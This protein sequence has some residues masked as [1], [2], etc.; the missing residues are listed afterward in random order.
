ML[1][2]VVSRLCS[3]VLLMLALTLVTFV[4]FLRIPIDPAPWIAG[5]QVTPEERAQIHH[6]LGLDRPALVQW[7]KFVERIV[8][9]GSLGESLM[10]QEGI[11]VNDIV[12]TALGRTASLVAGGFALVLL[13]SIP[14]GVLSALRPHTL[15]D[16]SVV[17]VAILGIV[18]HPFVVGLALR[19]LL[20]RRWH[21]APDGGYCP[22]HAPA[23]PPD[24][25]ATAG[26]GGLADWAGHLWLPWI[27]FAFFFLPLYTRMIRA[28]VLEN[29]GARYV[30]TARAKG[31]SEWR[32]VSRHVSRNVAGPVL[33]MLAV[34]V[35]T[36][37]TAAIYIETIFGLHGIGQLV[38][39]NLDGGHGYDLT[40]ILG[41][42]FVVAAA[43]T[44]LNLVADLATLALDPRIRV[45]RA[46]RA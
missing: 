41:V 43:I 25:F 2:Y 23:P 29:L 15:F 31:A 44:V 12:G 30:L 6:D 21:L 3:G 35:G 5:H 9:E 18:L 13:L 22:L 17:T 46:R 42:V 16:R 39:V 1:R 33:A 28:R 34:D 14:L 7:A 26:C 8:T 38:A 37:V 20:A 4:V 36:I 10:K 24:S 27:T 45:G 19:A 40:V 11:H 32:V